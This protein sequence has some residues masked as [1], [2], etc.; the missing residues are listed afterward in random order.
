MAHVEWGT[1]RETQVQAE[2]TSKAK[3]SRHL[4]AVEGGG[5]GEREP[6]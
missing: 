6:A 3:I 4:E 1:R 2:E 5:D